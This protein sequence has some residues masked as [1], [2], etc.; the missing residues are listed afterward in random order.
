MSHFAPVWADAQGIDAQFEDLAAT[1]GHVDGVESVRAIFRYETRGLTP[2]GW[3]SELVVIVSAAAGA[4]GI[5]LLDI[6]G[7][8]VTDYVK[9]K[10]DA[11]YP[12]TNVSI[13]DHNGQVV[14]KVRVD[15][16]LE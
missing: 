14:K 11:R 4:I 16:P 10:R 15:T 12:P 6:L 7:E 8:L 2:E 9:R 1:L 5:K 13:Y 3:S